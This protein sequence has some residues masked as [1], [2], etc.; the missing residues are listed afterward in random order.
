M[1]KARERIGALSRREYDY[2]STFYT[3]EVIGGTLH[4]DGKTRPV[5]VFLLGGLGCVQIGKEPCASL[6]IFPQSSTIPTRPYH[7]PT[8]PSKSLHKPTTAVSGAQTIVL[9]G[10][11]SSNTL[12]FPL[13][14][15]APGGIGRVTPRYW[16][17]TTCARVRAFREDQRFETARPSGQVCC[18]A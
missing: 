17:Q 6:H 15:D 3:R 16:N 14:G 2:E 5:G 1:T 10:L 7:I 18:D 12:L 11:T 4:A 8:H 13:L 9:I